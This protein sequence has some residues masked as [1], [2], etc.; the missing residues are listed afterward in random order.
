[1]LAIAHQG[2]AFPVL[3]VLLPKR[4]NSNT[5]ERIDLIARW[6]KIFPAQSVAYLTAD[7]EFLGRQWFGYLLKQPLAFRIRI[8]QSDTLS[9][10]RGK[11]IKA[12]ILFQDLQ[13]NEMKVLPKRRRLWGRWLYVAGLRLPDGQL[14]VVVT[15]DSPQTAIADYARRWQ[16]ET[17]FGCLK[18]RGFRLE[19]THLSEPERLSKLIALLTLALCWAHRVGNWR[20][21]HKPLKIKKHGRKA[22]SIFRYGFDYLRQILLNL[23]AA[24]SSVPN[25]AAIFV[26]YLAVR[27]V[28]LEEC[29]DPSFFTVLINLGEFSLPLLLRYKGM[30]ITAPSTT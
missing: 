3:W 17:L 23:H 1:M 24:A 8:R 11:A 5:T 9:N 15:P 10:G 13:P 12:S 21:Q 2:V 26:L 27:V 14:L 16:I 29:G 25:S 22:K 6:L 19:D 20:Q 7:G 4:G 18:S 30:S 28:C